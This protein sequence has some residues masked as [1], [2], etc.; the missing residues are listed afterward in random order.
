MIRTIPILTGWLTSAGTSPFYSAELPRNMES[1]IVVVTAEAITGSPSAATIS[2]EIQLWHS[3]VGGNQE[4]VIL[5]GTG[6]S[7]V[8]SWL[9]LNATDN[10]SLLPDGAFAASIDVAAATTSA[11]T[12]KVKRVLGGFPWRLKIG[13]SLTGGTNPAIRL[14]AVAYVKELPPVG[15]D[16]VESGA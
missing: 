14:S 10:P 2:P 11:P 9:T 12:I 13:W 3:H 7:P 15:F 4:E 5:G 1:A 8:D 16:R 6:L